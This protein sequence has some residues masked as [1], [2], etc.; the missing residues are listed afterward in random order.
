MNTWLY[1]GGYLHPDNLGTTVTDWLKT[2]Q[3]S[4]DL[5]C[6]IEQIC[7]GIKFKALRAVV[8]TGYCARFKNS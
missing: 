1:S 2:S 4:Q 7:Q 8:R 3:K 5:W 6:S